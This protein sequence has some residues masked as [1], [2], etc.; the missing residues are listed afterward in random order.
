[1]DQVSPQVDSEK[2]VMPE[3]TLSGTSNLISFLETETRHYTFQDYWSLIMDMPLMI[4]LFSEHVKESSA[5][6][7]RIC[8][9][10]WALKTVEQL[11]P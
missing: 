2:L 1:M 4:R 9:R 11:W 5:K 10:Q 8:L 7:L 3:L 6:V